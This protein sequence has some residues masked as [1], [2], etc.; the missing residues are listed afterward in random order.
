[1][2]W[3]SVEGAQRGCQ[4]RL[5]ASGLKGLQPICYSIVF[6]SSL[7]FSVIF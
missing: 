2:T 4:K 3:T 7:F 6:Y 5:H 1:M